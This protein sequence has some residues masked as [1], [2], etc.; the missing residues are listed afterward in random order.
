MDKQKRHMRAPKRD[1]ELCVACGSNPCP[2]FFRCTQW[3][4]NLMD[5]TRWR[6]F[7]LP[8]TSLGITLCISF[9]GVQLGSL[10]HSLAGR[11]NTD[12]QIFTVSLGSALC[13]HLPTHSP[14]TTDHFLGPF[15]STMLCSSLETVS[16]PSDSRQV[17]PIL[18]S[19]TYITKHVQF[20][21]EHFA[22]FTL[23]VHLTPS[24]FS[25]SH[26]VSSCY[27]SADSV[28]HHCVSSSH[29]NSSL[30]DM[31][32]LY[33]RYNVYTVGFLS[34]VHQLLLLFSGSLPSLSVVKPSMLRMSFFFHV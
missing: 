23:S 13:T 14:C 20:H 22:H 10:S 34:K 17:Q 27:L 8:L 16:L 19:L 1:G 26:V 4:W 7:M 11:I 33:N 28:H 25:S 30:V 2:L 9:Q 5:R 24:S 6:C 21:L 18:H 29:W 3:S 15:T 31:K 32:R 12:F